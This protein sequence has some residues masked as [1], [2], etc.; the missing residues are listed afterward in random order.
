MFFTTFIL[1]LPNM[2]HTSFVIPI[3]GSIIGVLELINRTLYNSSKI[4]GDSSV[5]KDKTVP[6]R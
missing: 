6:M 5:V 1:S 3:W 2:L 4:E